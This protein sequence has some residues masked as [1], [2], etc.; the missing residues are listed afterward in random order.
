[1]CQRV[2]DGEGDHGE[3]EGLVKRNEGTF[4]S[5]RDVCELECSRSQQCPKTDVAV[6][7]KW[8]LGSAR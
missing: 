7:F 2:N 5:V 1:M 4:E 3:V 6:R 8:V